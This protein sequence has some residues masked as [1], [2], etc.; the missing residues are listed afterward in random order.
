VPDEAHSNLTEKTPQIMIENMRKYTGLMVVVLVLLAAGLVLTMKPGGSGGGGA[1]N[2]FMQVNDVSLDQNDFSKAGKNTIS[3]VQRLAQMQNYNDFFKF[4]EFVGTLTGNASS[5][6]QSHLNFVT[7][8][9]LLKQAAEELGLY[10]APEVAQKYIQDNMFKGRDGS[11]DAKLYSAYIES[12]GNLGLKEKDFQQLVAEYIVFIKTRDII[13]GGLTPS[14]LSTIAEDKLNR[15]D[16]GMSVV[17]FKLVDFE[18]EITPTE[19]EIKSYWETHKDRYKTERTLKLTYVLTNLDTSDE[20]K[21]PTPAADADPAAVSKQN[22]EYQE[23]LVSWTEQRKGHTKILT[24]IFSDFVD[25]VQDSEGKDFDKAAVVA[26]EQAGEDFSIVNTEAFTIGNAPEELKSLSLKNYQ[27]GTQLIDLIFAKKFNAEDIYHN[28]DNF[29]VG[30]DGNVAIRLNEDIQPK[31]KS[32]DDAKELAKANLISKLAGEAMT[33]AAEDAK[34]KLTAAVADSK[35]F[36]DAAKEAELTVNELAPF[37][38]SAPPTEVA[39]AA[40]FFRIAQITD[41]KTV[42]TELSTSDDSATIIYVATRTLTVEGDEALKE[43]QL[44]EQAAN[45]QKYWVFNAWIN[46]LTEKAELKLP[47]VQ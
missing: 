9:I 20:P 1:G 26:K 5:E 25:Q 46:G 6:T 39:N 13:G 31:V 29:T 19:D 40:S 2:E 36:S 43:T 35:S 12:L 34:T 37:N 28:F 8:R 23:K 30:R 3:A 44:V 45:S 15:Q 16:I 21:R 38:E 14:K 4:R 33:K 27:Q 17:S 41:P 47:N 42:A 7:N 32:Y 24:K 22:P 11:H 10:S 18:K